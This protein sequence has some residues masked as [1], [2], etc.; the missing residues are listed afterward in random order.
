MAD[1]AGLTLIEMPITFVLRHPAVTAPI[2]GP[3]TMEHLDSQ[4]AAADDNRYDTTYSTESDDQP[5]EDTTI[6]ST[7]K[8]E[9]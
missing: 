6:L 5:V 7:E 2:I 3:R 8:D 9:S 1:D 4:L